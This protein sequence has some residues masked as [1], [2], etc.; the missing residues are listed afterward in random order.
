MV[1]DMVTAHLVNLQLLSNCAYSVIV[2]RR[3]VMAKWYTKE[4]LM[5][6][7]T[8]D[9]NTG[10][11][12]VTGKGPNGGRPKHP[13][14]RLWRAFYGEIP[15]GKWI[16]HRCNGGSGRNGCCNPTHCYIGTTSDNQLDRFRDNRH[17]PHYYWQWT[18]NNWNRVW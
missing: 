6:A 12:Y 3:I 13:S 18:K 1:A 4:H 16:L 11:W 15:D 2:K 10:C 9:G 5:A 17:K 14:R 7:I 8:I